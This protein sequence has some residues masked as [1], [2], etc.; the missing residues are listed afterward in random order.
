MCASCGA[1]E[2]T[3]K[4]R[5]GSAPAEVHSEAKAPPAEQE[6]REPPQTVRDVRKGKGSEERARAPE[7]PARE[8]AVEVQAFCAGLP[9]VL[10]DPAVAALVAD[11][12]QFGREVA[13]RARELWTRVRALWNR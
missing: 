8:P 3:G 5:A 10:L 12:E 4:H 6:I 7:A 9:P 13:P 1:V 2:E 11:V